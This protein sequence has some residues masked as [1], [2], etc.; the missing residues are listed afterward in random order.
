MGSFMQ[1]LIDTMV[2]L[3]MKTDY[4]LK[5]LSDGE[6]KVNQVIGIRK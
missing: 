5:S 3:T 4:Y 2:V 6:P 1:N